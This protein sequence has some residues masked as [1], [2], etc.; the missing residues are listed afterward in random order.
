MPRSKKRDPE[1]MEDETP[2]KA[3]PKR[4]HKINQRQQSTIS[5]KSSSEEKEPTH[6][7]PLNR[8]YNMDEENTSVLDGAS[9]DE[10]VNNLRKKMVNK[11]ES[12]KKNTNSSLSKPRIEENNSTK[13]GIFANDLIYP[14]KGKTVVIT[15]VFKS[16]SDRD[17]IKD[18]LIS[19]G[20]RVTG[21]VSNKTDILLHGHELEDGR[22]YN[23]GKKYKDA[24]TKGKTILSEEELS[25]SLFKIKGTRLEHML[26]PDNY[27]DYEEKDSLIKQKKDIQTNKSMQI[28][29]ESL[30]EIP[31]AIK[32]HKTGLWVDKYAPLSTDEILGN[33]TMIKKLK[34]WLIDRNPKNQKAC[35]ISGPP[36]IGKTTAAM[37]AAKECG[38][39]S[40]VQNASDVRNKA[41]VGAMMSVLG[42]NY[43][44]NNNIAKKCVIIMDE[45]DGMSGDRGGI[46]ELIKQIK[47]SKQPI[48]CICNDRQSPKIRTLANHCLDIRFKAPNEREVMELLANVIGKEYNANVWRSLDKSMFTSLI[49]AA[50]GDIRQVLNH[51]QMWL[52]EIESHMTSKNESGKDKLTFNNP[53]EAAKLLLNSNLYQKKPINDLKSMFFI[54]YNLVHLFVFENYATRTAKE[55]TLEQ[56]DIALDSFKQGD[57]VER[58]IKENRD[59]QV[60][61][62]LCYFSA[63]RPSLL[64]RRR[65]EFLQFP[66]ILAKYSSARKKH[67]LLK[68][69]RNSFAKN[70]TFLNDNGV[71]N[72]TYLLSEIITDLMESNKFDALYDLYNAY[73]LTTTSV[74]ENIE[75]F[76]QGNSQSKGL[77]SVSAKSKSNFTKY[78]NERTGL[79]K[80][81]TVKGGKKTKDNISTISK[82]PDEE[83]Y[84]EE[85]EDAEEVLNE[86]F[87]I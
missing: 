28:E 64:I 39:E 9:D 61:N 54:D 81:K 8:V 5:R 47:F 25:Q 34:S 82:E 52:A 26:N 55:T 3:A 72:Y 15:G 36:G 1:I 30:E 14:L 53:F 40:I 65:L 44:I 6:I 86:V 22:P 71:L 2:K 23:E 43:V 68:E 76:A 62:A 50:Q 85:D 77:E 49:T 67:R 79:T 42:G 45:V 63:I 35:L 57:E 16:T 21:S 33:G 74:K 10:I 13:A 60:L 83:S 20:A 48:I 4:L 17:R 75:A 18:I 56:L 66:L 38:Y 58:M 37:L 32:R 69:L 11:E 27:S 31:K 19:L 46:A 80:S 51:L 12:A 59:Y 84:E 29:Q 78:Y 70:T 7:Q 87:D 73:D 41:N 24:Q